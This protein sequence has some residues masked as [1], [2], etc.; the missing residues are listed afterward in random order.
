M[1][2]GFDW[3]HQNV[4][5]NTGSDN[6]TF[7][8]SIGVST[9][10]TSE[11][12]HTIVFRYQQSSSSAIVETLTEQNDPEY[13]ALFGTRQNNSHNSIEEILILAPGSDIILLLWTYIK[14]D[15]HPEDQECYTIS[16]VSTDIKGVR[17]LFTCN[18]D[19]NNSTKFFCDHTICID[20]DD[21]QFTSIIMIVSCLA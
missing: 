1:M 11:R 16:I 5:E 6:E 13:D 8:L 4:S 17:E 9:M 19:E 2:L 12:T 20:D 3:R 21:G 14:S 10:R 15:N 7:P 18:E